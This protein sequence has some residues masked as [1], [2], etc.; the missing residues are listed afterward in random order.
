MRVG[1]A[2]EIDIDTLDLR[3]QAQFGLFLG[4]CA[5]AHPDWNAAIALVDQT[6]TVDAMNSS[7]GYRGGAFFLLAQGDV[8]RPEVLPWRRYVDAQSNVR[9]RPPEPA[10]RVRASC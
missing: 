6:A 10:R 3:V 7:M 2:S 5:D 9:R 4:Y 1:A 8:L